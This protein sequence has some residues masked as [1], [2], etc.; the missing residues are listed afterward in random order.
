M[1]TMQKYDLLLHI[2]EESGLSSK[3]QMKGIVKLFPSFDPNLTNPAA[4]APNDHL[5][6]DYKVEVYAYSRSLRMSI[7]DSAHVA[8]MSEILIRQMLSGQGLSLPFFVK[9]VK[10]ELYAEATMKNKHL[11]RLD[12][13][14]QSNDGNLKALTTFLEKVYPEQYGQKAQLDIGLDDTFKKKWQIEVTHVD[15]VRKENDD[16]SQYKGQTDQ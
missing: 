4:P 2:V 7:L 5:L 12:Q 1:D 10:A 14:A 16:P 13:D 8:E 6:S 9:L 3:E 11:K 15:H